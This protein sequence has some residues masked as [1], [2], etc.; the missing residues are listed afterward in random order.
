MMLTRMILGGQGQTLGPFELTVT[1]DA[2]WDAAVSRDA[3]QLAGSTIIIRGS[4][5]T[6]RKIIDR[7][8]SV[9]GQPLTIRSEDPDSS[10]PSIEL[11]GTVRGLNFA[12]LNLQMTGWP[13]SYPACFTLGTGTFGDIRFTE[14]TTFRHGYGAAQADFNTLAELPEY[15]RIDNIATASSSST[16]HPLSWQDTD[17]PTGWIEFFN[18]GSET[19]HV[20]VGNSG[21][22]ATTASPS[23]PPGT[24]LRISQ[25]D[26]DADTHFAVLTASGTSEVNARTEIG[27]SE[28]LASAF[29]QYG[30][31]ILEN[32]ELR[33]CLFRDLSNAVKSLSPTQNAI[34]MDCD[35]DRIYQDVMALSPRPGASLHILRNIECLPFARSGIAE[36]LD[37]DARDPHGDQFQ[38]F[39][40]TPGT[41]GPIFYAG[42]RIK[43][44]PRRSGVINQGIFVSDNDFDPSFT[45]LYFISTMQI[46]G[47]R[48][49]LSLGEENT[50]FKVRNAFVYGAT[51]LDGADLASDAPFMRIDHDD[52]GT[53]YVGKSVA[54][55]FSITDAPWQQD[56]NLALPQVA[57]RTAVFPNFGDLPAAAD[58][59]SIEYALSTAAEGS[60]LGAEATSDAIDWN[61]DDHE[62]VI[63]WENL[64]S[65]AHWNEL[66][67]QQAGIEIEFPLRQILNQLPTQLVVPG[68]GTQW[69]STDV[70]GV[71]ELEPWT[72]ASGTI[73]PGQFIQIRHNSAATGN[74]K[75]TASIEINGFQQSVDISTQVTNQTFLEQGNPIGYFRDPSNVPAGTT[76]ITGRGKF[77]FPDNI[78]HGRRLFAQVSTACDL[79]VQA[80]GSLRATIEDG[81]GA[82]MLN[83]HEVAPAGSIIP[84]TW[85]DIIFDVDQVNGVAQVSINSFSG[86]T[87]FT[88]ASNGVFQSNRAFLF[89][90]GANGITPIPAG[91]RIADLS[92]DF[93]GILHKQISNLAAV[94]NADAW[95]LGGDF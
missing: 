84:D 56:N 91:T 5:F 15:A 50:N 24:R 71:T 95:H 8:M 13:R 58:R 69:R 20:E 22:L 67:N 27:L 82:K 46:G 87:S 68:A 81:T 65:G 70:D 92:V 55:E 61:S 48:R 14:G 80:N 63:L 78:V 9:F 44:S 94:A 47:A 7:D 72:G 36:D 40:N 30:S 43:L 88:G 6:K 76:R 64:P 41:V 73:E 10:I 23:V 25:L 37:G 59:A 42:N 26:P 39:N 2:E 53:V 16:T 49:A 35:F 12:G 93:N 45:D 51:L 28:Y 52:D 29:Q 38:I 86:T 34:V 4:N 77:Y 11:V 21:I 19:V 33:N 90:A 31:A 1:S 74:T 79:L 66:V 85:L 83:N 17:A 32:I 62:K 60:G 89:L 57:D 18:R 3:A 54:P 75:V